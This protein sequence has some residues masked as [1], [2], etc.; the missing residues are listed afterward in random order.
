MG[1]KKEIE[2]TALK[3]IQQKGRNVEI[4]SLFF[5]SSFAL[6]LSKVSNLLLLRQRKYKSKGVLTFKPSPLNGLRLRGECFL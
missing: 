2:E 6:D 4:A 1:I 5:R 3:K